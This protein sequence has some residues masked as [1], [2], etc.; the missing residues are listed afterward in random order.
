MGEQSV[1]LL[2]AF[3]RQPFKRRLAEVNRAIKKGRRNFCTRTCATLHH[4]KLHPPK[5]NS[6][7]LTADNRWTSLSPFKWFTARI[8]YRSSCNRVRGRVLESKGITEKYLHDL[9]IKQRGRCPI[10]GW[11]LELPVSTTGWNGARC[12]KRASLDRINTR[13]G[14]VRGNVRFVSY[15]ANIARGDFSDQDLLDFC[16]VVAAKAA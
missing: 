1:R 13:K 5:G 9:W 8:R 11:K 4:N 10:T 12:T 2:C 14:Y 15:M 16:R 7:N 3:C 6:A